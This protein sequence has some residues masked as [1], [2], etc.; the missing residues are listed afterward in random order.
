M[1]LWIGILLAYH[2]M[3][4]S[5]GSHYR[6][7]CNGAYGYIR[8]WSVRNQDI[9]SIPLWIAVLGASRG[10]QCSPGSRA[11]CIPACDFCLTLGCER[12]PCGVGV[13]SRCCVDSSTGLHPCICP[14]FSGWTMALLPGDCQLTTAVT[15][16]SSGV[17]HQMPMHCDHNLLLLCDSS[18]VNRLVNI[19]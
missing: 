15:V 17:V 8:H 4:A 19:C 12:C 9:A 3:P 7:C 16:P 18:D 1:S 11:A 13:H 14:F 2:Y 5:V 10:R 6:S